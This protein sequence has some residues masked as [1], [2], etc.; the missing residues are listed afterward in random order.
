MTGFTR[1]TFL[2]LLGLAGTGTIGCTSQDMGVRLPYT[3]PPESIIPGKPFW[4]ATTCRE[5]PA[6][7]GMLAK[8]RDGRIIKVEG[9]PQSPVNQG[10]LCPRGQASITRLYDPD[11]IQ[12]PLRKT[13]N[14]FV[15]M[16]WPEAEKVLTGELRKVIEK[17]E[18]GRLV[19]ITDLI[20][21]PLRE[22]VGQW[23]SLAE[24]SHVIFEPFIYEPLKKAN[25]IVFGRE[26]IPT[27]R[28]DRADF[29][30]SFNA[31]FLETWLSNVQYARRFALFHEPRKGMKNPF[32]F[33]GPRHSITAANADYHVLVNPGDEHLVAIGILLA[34]LEGGRYS[35]AG[36]LNEVLKDYSVAGIV[37]Q[38]GVAEETI[39]AVAIRFSEAKRP[40]ALAEGLTSFSA[41]GAEAAVAANLLNSLN[42]GTE[43]LIQWDREST[44]GHLAQPNTLKEMFRRMGSGGAD[45]LLI[46]NANP[47]FTLPPSWNVG[48][49][50]NRVPTR[51]SFSPFPDETSAA[52]D[53]IFPTHTP[54]ESWGEFSPERGITGLMQP[55]MGNLYDTRDLGDAL[56]RTGKEVSGKEG[57]PWKDFHHLL[58]LSWERRWKDSGSDRPFPLFWAEALRRGG[59][60]AEPRAEKGE[61]GKR[62]PERFSFLSS[63]KRNSANGDLRCIAY[64]TIQFYDGRMA[65]SPWIQELPDSITQ[66]TWGGWVEIHPET[67]KG[68]NIAKGDLLEIRSDYGIMTAPALPIPT[69]GVGTVA[70]PLGQGHVSYGRFSAGLPANPAVLFPL[71]TEEGKATLPLFVNVRKA[72]ERFPIANTDGS[73]YEHGRHIVETTTI[74]KYLEDLSSDKKPKITM[75]LP[76]GWDRKRDVY[77]V[78]LHSTYRW[79]MVVD[80]D[81][82]IGCGACVTACYAENNVAFVGREQML[83][84]REMSWIRVQRYFDSKRH[85]A[86]WLVML[87]QHCDAAPCESVCPIYAPH[88][89]MDG[90]NNQIYNRCFGT[91][92]CS[93][94]DPYKVRRFNWYTWERPWP[95]DLQLNPD[96]TVRQK[97]VMEKC[98][99]CI[100]RITEAKMHAR[101]E[102]RPVK[103]GDFTTACA[104]TCPTNALIFGNLIDPESRVSRLIHNPRAYQV[105]HHLNTKPAVIYLKR[106]EQSKL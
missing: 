50:L 106:I 47:L 9:N 8:N 77:D 73:F 10:A 69:V 66:V 95:L 60:Y 101:E 54:L 1:R 33:V 67:A 78:H 98:S 55:V 48:D 27:Y 52:A 42:P 90:L 20:T 94:N 57:F 87:C 5:C 68:L 71:E 23:V 39:R 93:Q 4:F 30:I 86:R 44:Q 25:R 15:P 70:I 79:A 2:K 14:G 96:V 40:L 7:C 82:C 28:I 26:G 81:R 83:K 92:F 88:H 31:G 91:R 6:G 34:L 99:F 45:L 21:G 22:L 104:Q 32:V 61:Y 56:I 75:P 105:L 19:F 41:F 74:E 72:G 49:A 12:R 89:S 97:G 16:S 62:S 38:T 53:F 43:G 76:S 36:M 64:P 103:D 102:D 58:L 35:R 17:R 46:H 51:I 11:R 80:L 29:L 59:F 65:N 24:G 37:E 13:A 85:R 100:Q 63:G 3:I 18:P 84:G